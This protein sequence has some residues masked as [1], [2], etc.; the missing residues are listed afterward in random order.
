MTPYTCVRNSPPFSYPR[1]HDLLLFIK[2]IHTTGQGGRFWPPKERE[3][4]R[5][6]SKFNYESSSFVPFFYFFGAWHLY[7]SLL[8]YLRCQ[9]AQ[10]RKCFSDE[11]ARGL[12]STDGRNFRAF[13]SSVSLSLSVFRADFRKERK[14]LVVVHGFEF[15]Y[16]FF[17]GWAT[18]GR[19]QW[20]RVKCCSFF[21]LFFRLLLAE[22]KKRERIGRADAIGT[23]DYAPMES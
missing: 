15:S 18:F 12:W 1:T 23:I 17:G 14:S 20:L 4:A 22:W 7:T 21:F 5:G 8:A 13:Y 16:A 11:R 9:S 10:K 6:V 19:T 3:T 2:H